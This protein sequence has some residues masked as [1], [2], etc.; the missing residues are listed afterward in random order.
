M[1]KNDLTPFEQE[2]L[3][4]LNK[5]AM[6]MVKAEEY[7]RDAKIP[8]TTAIFDEM[9]E[10]DLEAFVVTWNPENQ[11]KMREKY[12]RNGDLETES[13]NQHRKM[14]LNQREESG[15]KPI[16]VYYLHYYDDLQ[17]ER[18]FNK[19]KDFAICVMAESSTEAIEKAKVIAQNPNIKIMGIANGKE[20]W[21]N[22]KAPMGT[23]EEC[24]PLGGW[25]SSWKNNVKKSNP[26][27]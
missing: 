25:D 10:G 23:G 13:E 19:H 24:M 3:K 6:L 16:V 12:T 20:S 5:K 17:L 2:L 4:N 21:V 15:P 14:D 1:N 22:E 9:S 26:N 27:I 11:K 8:F 18:A 7:L